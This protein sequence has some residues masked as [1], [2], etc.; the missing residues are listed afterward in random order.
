MNTETGDSVQDKMYMVAELDAIFMVQLSEDSWSGLPTPKAPGPQEPLEKPA[1]AT[2]H[3][4]QIHRYG[5]TARRLP[6]QRESEVLESLK[7]VCGKTS[8][9]AMRPRPHL[10]GRPRWW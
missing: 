4:P 6:A 8:L 9:R 2:A 1:A 7:G 5:G 10:G 3:H